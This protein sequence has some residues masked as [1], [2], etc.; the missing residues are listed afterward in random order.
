MYTPFVKRT[1]IYLDEDR[2]GRV[3]GAAAAEGRSA[4]ALIR[5]AVRAY[6]DRRRVPPPDPFRQLIGAFEGPEDGAEEHDFYVY[7][8]RLAR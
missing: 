6:L 7:G 3:R 2:D 1:Q 4:A 8:R 5:D